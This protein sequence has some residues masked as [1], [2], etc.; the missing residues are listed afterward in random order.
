MTGNANYTSWVNAKPL[1]YL[2]WAAG[3]PAQFGTE[4][5][6]QANNFHWFDVSCTQPLRYACEDAVV[7][8]PCFNM[9]T[10]HVLSNDTASWAQARLN[11]KKLGMELTSLE[12]PQ[13]NICVMS[14]LKNAGLTAADRVWHSLNMFGQPNFDSWNNG[15]PLTYVGWSPG[16]PFEFPWQSCGAFEY[17]KWGDVPCDWKLRY[18]CESAQIDR[19]DPDQFVAST[20]VLTFDAAIIECKKNGMALSVPETREENIC[21][22]RLLDEKGLTFNYVW[23]GLNKKGASNYTKWYNEAPLTYL[24]WNRG[25]PAQFPHEQCGIHFFSHWYDL[26]CE[27][28]AYY[29]CEKT[30]VIDPCKGLPS[31]YKVSTDTKTWGGARAECKKQGGDLVSIDSA[32]EHA[33]VKDKIDLA[34]KTTSIVFHGLNK[35]GWSNYTSLYSGSTPTATYWKSGEPAQFK[36]EHCSAYKDGAWMDVDCKGS[37]AYVCESPAPIDVC[38]KYSFSVSTEARVYDD[39]RFECLKK[40]MTIVDLDNPSKSMCLQQ[41]IAGLE[42]SS[43]PLTIGL[44]KRRTLNHTKWSNGEL[45]TFTDWD[46]N[47]PEAFAS[48][49]CAVA[50]NHH[51]HDSPC[52][53]AYRYVCEDDYKDPCE[54]FSTYT[55]VTNNNKNW[56]YASEEC[57]KLGGD[58]VSMETPEENFC[59]RYKIY[60]AGKKDERMWHSL[61]KLGTVYFIQWANGE[62]LTYSDFD[63]SYNLKSWT[64]EHCGGFESGI[65]GDIPCTWEIPYVCE[66]KPSPK[67]ICTDGQFEVFAEQVDYA[68]SKLRCKSKGMAIANMETV[69]ENICVQRA[70]LKKGVY[71]N[72]VYTGLNKIGQTNYTKWENG[73]PLTYRSFPPGEPSGFAS[74]DCMLNIQGQWYD[75]NCVVGNYYVCEKAVIVDPCQGLAS[76]YTISTDTQTWGAARAACKLKSADLATVKTDKDHACIKDKIAMAGKSASIVFIGLNKIGQS[77]YL[78][79][80]DGTSISFTAWKAG[81][82]AQLKTENCA[83][84]LNDEWIDT[85]CMGSNIYVCESPAKQDVCAKYKFILSSDTRIYDDAKFECIMKNSSLVSAETPE[86]NLCLGQYLVEMGFGVTQHWIGMDKRGLS[87]YSQWLSG[88]AL[89]YT[90]WDVNNP[91]AFATEDCVVFLN[92]HWVDSPCGLSWRYVCETNDFKH[93]CDGFSSY[94]ISTATKKWIDAK[95]DCKNN[96]GDL[97]TLETPQENYCVQF[98]IYA[99]GKKGAQ[100]W[101][102]LNKMGSMYFQYWANGVPLNYSGFAPSYNLKSWTGAHCAAFQNSLWVEIGCTASISYVCE[103]NPAPTDNCKTGQFEAFP[104]AVAYDTAKQKCVDKGLVLASAETVQENFCVQWAIMRKGIEGNWVYSGLNK[105]GQSNYTKWESNATLDYVGWAPNEPA[106]F[107]SEDCVINI[108]GHW[109]DVSCGHPCYYVC[110]KSV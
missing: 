16:N 96:N 52:G 93:P 14:I 67:E 27:L 54:D 51:W 42:L 57:K 48:E 94:T 2:D 4:K 46:V 71:D 81:E 40:N 76:T 38:S 97:A 60:M 19:C 88:S 104:D 80:F 36:T 83:A 74:E 39:A 55:I 56:I 78:Q 29:V 32:K 50:L 79:W 98:L 3:N 77:N 105:R 21:I 99:A 61:S 110:E 20:S 7:L 6:V 31:T 102:S 101:H 22:Q 70:I 37:N 92:Q 10:K 49:H 90:D 103:S 59:V 17:G 109:Y 13:E 106:A 68:T 45:L 9:T 11:C 26:P 63:P 84:Y 41:Y 62:P 108:D 8:D 47:N 86:E 65:W 64:G 34:G 25:E 1:L 43:T 100:L 33:C 15:E 72:W 58:L 75:I 23:N 44:D 107:A 87:N 35:M 66:S 53:V 85:P 30:I 91:E 82:P 28:S 95:D 5:C 12:T 24:D 73:A 69:T 89:T 18:V